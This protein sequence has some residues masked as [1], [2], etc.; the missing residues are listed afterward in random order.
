MAY[1]YVQRIP[2]SSGSRDVSRDLF[3]TA[4]PRLAEVGFSSRPIPEVISSYASC[5]GSASLA[6]TTQPV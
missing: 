5:V 3:T 2:V 6:L 4:S 1:T